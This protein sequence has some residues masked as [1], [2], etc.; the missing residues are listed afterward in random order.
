MEKRPIDLS[1][2]ENE[3]LRET[4]VAQ[5]DARSRSLR[6]L[7]GILQK[8]KEDP[9]ILAGLLDRLH[10]DVFNAS[11]LPHLPKKLRL[12]FEKP[13]VPSDTSLAALEEIQK[14]VAERATMLAQTLVEKLDAPTLYELGVASFEKYLQETKDASDSRAYDCAQN[15]G[16]GTLFEQRALRQNFEAGWK[17]FEAF[18]RE[19]DMRSAKSEAR[20]LLKLTVLPNDLMTKYDPRTED[21]HDTRLREVAIFYARQL[22]HI[23]EW[24]QMRLQEF[25]EKHPHI[26]EE[27][28][29]MLDYLARQAFL[30]SR[31]VHRQLMELLQAGGLILTGKDDED[32]RAFL[33]PKALEEIETLLK[34][35]E[36]KRALSLAQTYE[37]A[38]ILDWEEDAELL[39]KL[40]R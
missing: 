5:E 21:P 26:G 9:E 7:E 32:I 10:P 23:V 28:Q 24:D 6:Y 18:R 36:K 11:V 3:S 17:K 2:Q 13:L 40:T 27:E 39:D 4:V 33:R 35:N 38:G 20:T 8:A 15:F 30:S 1:P 25:K 22:L 19:G 16:L 34:N 12:R 14:K 29:K 31:F 37:S